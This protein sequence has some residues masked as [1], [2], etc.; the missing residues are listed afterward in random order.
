MQ[1]ISVPT[2]YTCKTPTAGW[3][4]LAQMRQVMDDEDQKVI[5]VY[6]LNGD[7]SVFS[8]ENADAIL[9][10]LK[11]AQQRCECENYRLKNR[12]KQYDQT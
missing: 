4:N 7:T 12:R 3:V 2:V 6:W 9:S 11:E 5:I 10:A 1:I 8:G